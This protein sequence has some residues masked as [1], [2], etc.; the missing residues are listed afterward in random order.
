MPVH[1]ARTILKSIC[2]TA[3]VLLCAGAGRAGAQE[4]APAASRHGTDCTNCHETPAGEGKP[5]LKSAAGKLCVSCHS[6]VTEGK[7]FVHGALRLPCTVC[8]DP[9]ESR[10]PRLLRAGINDLCMECH[11]GGFGGSA[12]VT[13]FKGEVK[14][15]REAVGNLQPLPVRA[16]HPVPYH[17]VFAAAGLGQREINCLSCH[18][19]HA[20]EAS[21][22]L[23][24]SGASGRKGLCGKCHSPP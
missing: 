18:T 4:P 19:P 12:T 9:H 8:H 7:K 20:S 6:G 22:D 10:F 14:L 17:P 5:K 11:A 3:I 2:L 24:I 16:G 13:L 21:P 23:L 1:G 15:P